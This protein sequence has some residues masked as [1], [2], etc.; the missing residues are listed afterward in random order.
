M[1]VWIIGGAR[2]P[3]GS[4]GGALSGLAPEYLA[5]ISAES[6][7]QRARIEPSQVED[8]VFGNVIQ[9]SG[10]AAYLA[11]HVGL[12]CGVPEAAPALTVNRLCGSGLQ[13]IL[14]AAADIQAGHAQVAL[15][16]GTEVMSRA[17]YSLHGA[18][19]GHGLRTPELTDMLTATL[20]DEYAGCGMGETAETLAREYGITRAEQDEFALRSHRLAYEQRAALAQEICPIDV[21]V[22]RRAIALAHDEHVRPDASAAALANL[23]PAFVSDGTVTA[24]NSSGINDGAAAVVLGSDEV[25]ARRDE[26]CVRLVSWAV[27]GVEPRRMGIG[28]APALRQ[29][30]DRAQRTLAQMDV[31]EINE[32]FAAQVLAVARELEIDP[33]RINRWGGAIAC[34]H[35]V[36]ASGARLVLTA[37]QQL[38][39]LNG[40]FAAVSLC[41]GG[42]Q[43]IAAVLERC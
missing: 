13:A 36:G 25:R 17:P 5:Q 15:A 8:V 19:F 26:P 3:F 34:G 2:T 40:R 14:S 24:G 28:P 42:G 1:D 39:A 38:H 31:I 22:A 18:R 21:S 6:A 43:G 9:A 7:L 11:R 4:F 30:L 41:I 35:P 29:A 27:V 23:R 12:R 37:C 16:G 33:Q 10:Q 20:Q 32:A